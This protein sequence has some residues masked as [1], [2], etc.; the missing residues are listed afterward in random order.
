MGRRGETAAAAAAAASATP[1]FRPPAFTTRHDT[2]R[3]GALFTR[4]AGQL[5]T[6]AQQVKIK[7]HPHLPLK[8]RPSSAATPHPHHPVLWSRCIMGE[9]R[10]H[11]TSAG[12]AR[13]Q[14][15]HPEIQYAVK[16]RIYFR[17]TDTVTRGGRRGR[18]HDTPSTQFGTHLISILI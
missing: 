14:R 5:Q 15:E 10:C 2:T 17:I 4:S 13:T 18:S 9:S 11:S 16:T 3:R 12:P 7:K 6:K 8:E 1:F